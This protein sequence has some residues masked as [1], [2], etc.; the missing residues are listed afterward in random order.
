LLRWKFIIDKSLHASII[1]P[2]V[3]I[4]E[5]LTLRAFSTTELKHGRSEVYN[6]VAESGIIILKHRD[7]PDMYICSQKYMAEMM[8]KRHKEGKDAV[9]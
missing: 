1:D 8:A 5:G 4:I 9:K 3:P 7:R 6:E 2:F